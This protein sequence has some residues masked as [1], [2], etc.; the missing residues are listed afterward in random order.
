VRILIVTFFLGSLAIVRAENPCDPFIPQSPCRVDVNFASGEHDIIAVPPGGIAT[1][2]LTNKPRLSSCQAAYAPGP[3]TRSP[4]TAISGL[5]TTIGGLGAIGGGAKTAPKAPA[6][7]AAV[8]PPVGNADAAG[9][10]AQIAA[11]KSEENR[12]RTALPNLRTTYQIASDAIGKFSPSTT[13]PTATDVTDFTQ[14]LK[15]ALDNPIPSLA[16]LQAQLDGISRSLAAFHQ[17]YDPVPPGTQ[18]WLSLASDS[19]NQIAG[20]VAR[21]QDYISDLPAF[22]VTLNQTLAA[23]KSPFTT[24]DLPAIPAF[25]NSNVGVTITCKDN[26]TQATN[27]ITV[28]FTAY[29]TRLPILDLSVGPVFSLLGRRLVGTISPSAATLAA[30]PMATGTLGVTDSSSFQVIPMA[31]AEIHTRGFHCPW[32]KAENRERR[33][34]YVCSAGIALGVGPNNGSGVT[35][36]EF[37][38]GASFA[39]QRVSFLF[40]FHDGRVQQLAAGNTI[41]QSVPVGY[42]PLITRSWSVRPAFGIVYRMPLH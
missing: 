41:G 42:S 3:L 28:T 31:V 29:Y 38:E 2:H 37:F 34:G 15:A 33:Y 22:W 24:Q 26:I 23:L 10:D 21:D 6:F 40:G 19:V 12:L 13:E 39:I 11:L 30:N 5:L 9:L 27:Q 32:Y 25:Y 35:Q 1:I 17:K 14:K 4:D 36:A 16:S 18:A 7:A 8:P 20:A